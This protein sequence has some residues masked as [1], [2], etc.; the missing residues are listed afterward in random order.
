MLS[1]SR[2]VHVRGNQ[3]FPLSY[4]QMLSAK[5]SVMAGFTHQKESCRHS[6]H[7][8]FPC[9]SADYLSVHCCSPSPM[10]GGALSGI[11]RDTQSPPVLGEHTAPGHPELLLLAGV[12]PLCSLCALSCLYGTERV[13]GMGHEN[14]SVS[15]LPIIL[16]CKL[17]FQIFHIITRKTKIQTKAIIYSQ[18]K[19]WFS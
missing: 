5:P 18:T 3:E 1:F 16:C 15:V 6:H 8:H 4:S 17:L 7:H 2:N 10:A 11:S 13:L 14:D 12:S 19:L 9:C